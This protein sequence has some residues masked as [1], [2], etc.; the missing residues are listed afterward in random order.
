[1][2]ITVRQA[3][4]GDLDAIVMLLGELHDPSRAIGDADSWKAM[5]AQTGRTI[6]LAERD[7]DP[8]GTADLWIAPTLLNGAAPRAFVNYVAVLTS[9]RRSGVGRALLEDAHRRAA[10]AGCG[11]VLLMSGDHRPDAHRF[12]TAL[13]YERCARGLRKQLREE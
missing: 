1:V 6:L 12:Y 3:T 13:G 2:T 4:P 10:E 11:D 7:G 5:L 8:V 9:A